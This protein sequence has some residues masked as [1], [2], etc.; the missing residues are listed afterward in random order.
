MI[1]LVMAGRLG[2]QLFQYAM[3]RKIQL[4]T[5]QKIAIDFTAVENVKNPEWKNYLIDFNVSEYQVVSKQ[6]YYPIQRFIYRM[7]K[8]LRPKDR[9]KHYM[10]DVW[11]ARNLSRFGILYCESDYLA[12]HFKKIKS[13]N[14]II[15]GWFESAK[16]FKDIGDILKNEFIPNQELSYN[17]KILAEK[18]QNN[19]V[20]CV[21]IRRGNF[22]SNALKD[23]FLVCGSEYYY[24]GV[25]YIHERY[26]DAIIY[27]CSDDIEWC[28]KELQFKQNTIYEKENPVWEKLYLMTLCNHFVISNSTFSWWAQYLSAAPNKIVVAPY[29]W[30]NS[31]FPPQDIFEDTWV[32]LDENGKV[33][34]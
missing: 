11:C 23:K 28:K 18:L 15:R 16:Y 24:Q 29:R 5:G 21:T 33:V 12:V 26:T 27:V 8:T 14:V 13:K 30:R 9:R 20:I 1:Y 17:S 22:T 6:D 19:V 4:E 25:R 7:L 10:F 3:A 32:L 31:E 34:K 2:N